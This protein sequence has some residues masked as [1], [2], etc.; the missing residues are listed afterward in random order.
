M[1]DWSTFNAEIVREFRSNG[2][3]VTRFGGLPLIILHTVGAR[4]GIVREVPLIPVLEG[5]DM[6]VF[7]TAEGSPTHPAWYFNLRAHPRITVETA[8]GRFTADVVQLG[9]EDAASMVGPRAAAVAQLAEYVV[10]AAP[11]RIPV[12][13]INPI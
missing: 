7:A 8:E 5:D 12:F 11:R 1:R 6:F 10:S 9:D 2:G 3:R 4:S 13:S